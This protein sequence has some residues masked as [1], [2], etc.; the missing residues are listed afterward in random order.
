MEPGGGVSTKLSSLYT[1]PPFLDIQEEKSR[2]TC[3]HTE[4][5]ATYTSLVHISPLL[6]ALEDSTNAS[7]SC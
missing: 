1:P 7:A 6:E 4:G 2:M 5:G 3:L